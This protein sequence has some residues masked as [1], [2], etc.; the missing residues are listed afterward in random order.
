MLVNSIRSS[1]IWLEILLAGLMMIFPNRVSAAHHIHPTDPAKLEFS[2]CIYS[3]EYMLFMEG[4]LILEEREQK[5]LFLLSE[6]E[7]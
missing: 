7:L 6:T 4:L 1:Q 5:I 2:R 3:S